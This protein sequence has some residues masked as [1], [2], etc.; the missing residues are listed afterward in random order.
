MDLGIIVENGKIFFK[1]KLP[2]NKNR[3]RLEILN[4]IKLVI[5]LLYGYKSRIDGCDQDQLY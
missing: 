4:R 5:Q 3:V 2:D 1:Q